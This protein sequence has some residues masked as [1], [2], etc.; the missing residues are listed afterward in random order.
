MT[1]DELAAPATRPVVRRAP[2]AA[3]VRPAAL[4]TDALRVA[5]IGEGAYP[6]YPGGVSLFCHQLIKGMPEVS[7]TAVSL[8]VDGS[9][10]RT[11]TELD[12]LTEVVNIPLWGPSARRRP[13]HRVPFASF[14]KYYEILLRAI[15]HP[16]SRQYE[17]ACAEEFTVGLRGLYEY[18]QGGGLT[19]ALLR[20]EPLDLLRRTWHDAGL[21]SG[22]SGAA[23]PLTLDDAVV[24]TNRIEHLLRP[25]AHPPVS[26]DV[27]HLTMNGASAL[28]ALA[29]KWA[30]G[31]RMVLSEHGVYL[32]ERYLGL[33]SD[34]VSPAV[35]A[36]ATRF[37]RRLA[38]ATYR[39]ADILAPHSTYNRR[40]QLYGGADPARI[41]VMY[42]GINPDDF[43]LA[44]DEPADPTIVFVGRIDPLKDLR[45]LI[46][47]FA[48][49]REKIPAARLR[50]FGPVPAGNEQYQASC[51]R[52]IVDLGLSGAATFEGRIPDQA[53]AYRAGHLVALTSVSEGFPYTVVESMSM[54]RPVVCT[55][56]GGVS[57]AVDTA[58]FVVP[59]ADHVAVAHAC[60]RLLEDPGLR[61]TLGSLARQRVL[62]RFTLAQWCDAYQE[63]YDELAPAPPS[64]G[65][66][67]PGWENV[68]EMLPPPPAAPGPRHSYRELT[69]DDNSDIRESQAV[70]PPAAPVAPSLRRR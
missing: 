53:D 13:R 26:A 11:W 52:L 63:I 47:A 7:F 32:R 33:A 36:I 8:T 31:T 21:D 62:E 68:L 22:H 27:C 34:N 14:D 12:N 61:R 6:F 49:V 66:A 9:E 56:V 55:N 70:A 39:N 2:S 48:I 42:N 29:S 16:L 40:W 41:Q 60:I 35:K 59:P 17:Q 10:R 64:N 30:F 25:L 15:L 5:L 65:R 50:M 44:Q 3:V 43:P 54:G 1:T 46:R 51:A 45:T 69:R 19:E 23:G 4:A 57:E 38:A 28:V 18:A 20:N 58:G 24:A 37:N 67:F